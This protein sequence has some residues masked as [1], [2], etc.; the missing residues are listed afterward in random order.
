MAVSEVDMTQRLASLEACMRDFNS[1][2]H[3]DGLLVS[4]TVDI[5]CSKVKCLL[6][7]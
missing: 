1:E 6:T 2:L 5:Y 7:I 3:V 4:L